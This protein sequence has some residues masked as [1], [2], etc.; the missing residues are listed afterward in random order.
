MKLLLPQGISGGLSSCA[1]LR[2]VTAAR[3]LRLGMPLSTRGT[4]HSTSTN[5]SKVAKLA[6]GI[7][8]KYDDRL[9]KLISKSKVLTKLNSNPKFSH[10]FDRI[11]EAGTLS[12]F[13][14][15]LLIH[16]LTAILPLLLLWWVFYSLDIHDGHDLPHVFQNLVDQCGKAI[17]KLVGDKYNDTL[18]K[19]RLVIAGTLAYAI[20]KLLYPVRILFSIWGAPYVGKW[21]LLPFYKLA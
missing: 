20:V 4:H 21:L 11:S 2:Q 19:G 17:N 16:E 5:N 13:A 8:R 12:T 9:H 3:F 15:F 6:G 14:S 1:P 18:D 10:Y 7:E